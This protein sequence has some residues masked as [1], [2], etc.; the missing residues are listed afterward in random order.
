MLVLEGLVGLHRTVGFS[1]FGISVWGIDLDY[2]D[3]EWFALES[4]RDHSVI[5]GIASKYCI[6]DSFVYYEGY[7]ISSKGFLPTLVDIMVIWIKFTLSCP[8]PKVLMFTLAISYLTTSNLPWFMDLTFQVPMQYCS[9][10]HQTLLSLPVTSTTGRCFHFGSASS[11]P[12]E[13][14]VHSSPV[15]LWG[16]YW[17]LKFISVMSSCEKICVIRSSVSHVL[18]FSYC[19][20]HSPGK[21]AD[22]VCQ[23]LLQWTTFCQNSPPWL[24]H[25]EWPHTA[26]LI[27]SLS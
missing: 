17:P 14:F 15:A 2:C 21:N 1:F 27:F 25:L 5:F 9:W 6:F 18:V 10:Q 4:N 11:F 3:S 12:L 23:S 19:S 20:W 24:V 16:T 7:S 26:W 22:V 13:L 8:F